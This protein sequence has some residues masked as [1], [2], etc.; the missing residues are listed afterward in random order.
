MNDSEEHKEWRPLISWLFIIGLSVS[1][2]VVMMILMLIMEKPREW[3]FGTIP[4]TPSESVY[5]SSNKQAPPEKKMIEPLPEGIP[6]KDSS[7]V[8]QK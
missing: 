7:I 1:L 8:K 2:F 4:F 5:S 3:D 6:M